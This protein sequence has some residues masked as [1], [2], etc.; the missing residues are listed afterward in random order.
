MGDLS[1]T[2]PSFNRWQARRKELGFKVQAGAGEA[3]PGEREERGGE[4]R[5]GE[6]RREGVGRVGGGR[7]EMG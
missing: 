4:E 1:L 5:R 2:L 6:E 7:A 3:E